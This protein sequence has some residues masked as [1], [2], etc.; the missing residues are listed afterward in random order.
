MENLR[1]YDLHCDLLCYLANDPSRSAYDRAVRCS[2]P[3]LKEGGVHLQV[4]PIFTETERN[5]AVKGAAQ[6]NIFKKLSTQYPEEFHS[7]NDK[8]FEEKGVQTLLAIENASS[9]SEEE[10]PFELCIKKL[11]FIRKTAGKIVYISLTWNTENRFG[12][13]AH[14]SVGLK[15]EGK[16]LLDHLHGKQIAVD[17]SHASDP[18]AYDLL[19]YI[20]AKN[21]SIPV[22]ASHSNFRAVTDA[23][24]NLPD[25]LALEIWRR[26]GIVGLN[27]VR[28][29]LGAE[30]PLFFVKQLEHVFKLGGATQV[31]FGADFFYDHDMSPLYRKPADVL[32]FPE[33][34]DATAYP[35][36]M[37]LWKKHLALDEG[38]LQN[39]AYKNL[40]SFLKTNIF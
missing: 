25:E 40:E 38:I 28:F 36:V 17:L 20:D 33:F 12:G 29:F 9:F 1:I 23:L 35:K 16:L 7:F 11:E 5:S 8:C 24:R 2:I 19:N 4:M 6:L 39:I 27:F 14:T 34:A 30:T 26:K 21:L 22:M 15:K 18:L 10:E 32:F 31:C 3:Q 37:H 13:G